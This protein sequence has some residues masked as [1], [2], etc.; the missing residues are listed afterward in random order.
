STT[1]VSTTPLRTVESTTT[2][3]QRELVD[4]V[5]SGPTLGPDELLAGLDFIPRTVATT[6]TTTTST[7]TT[8]AAPVTTSGPAP[9]RIPTPTCA[10]GLGGVT[11]VVAPFLGTTASIP[12]GLPA[13]VV[14]VSNNNSNSRR[15]LIGLDQADI[16]FEERIEGTATR[17]AA[18]FH[19]R[20]PAN[21]G[22]V[23]SGRTTDIQILWNLG[24]PVLGYSGS[25]SGVAR[26][27][28]DAAA[29]RL[30]VPVV[31]TDRAPFARDSRYRAPD[32]L[33]VD[34]TSLGAC[35]N[36][37]TP[38]S[39]FEYG[40]ATSTTAE[41]A[42]SVLLQARSPFRFDWDAGSGTWRRSQDGTAHLT[43]SGQQLAPDNVV[44]LFVRYVQS[45]IDASSVDA[46]TVGSGDAWVL[47]DGTITVG[48]WS[49]DR[50]GQGYTFTDASGT[51]TTLT[52]GSTWVVLA[53]AGSASWS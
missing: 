19:S 53:P 6:T 5:E 4:V 20:L 9:I 24:L 38:R 18:V 41:P 23:R 26:Q 21:V 35:G 48:G 51:S 43:R 30:F 17:F 28:A 29:N 16:V 7:T 12:T 2:V 49:R 36:G 3:V 46:E 42:T 10:S 34:P 31:N 44:V 33:F 32:N 1:P 45:S 39:I 15:A 8:T 47:R 11:T 40:P 27:F 37:G 14:K 22:P 25:N 50:A 52:P 13:V